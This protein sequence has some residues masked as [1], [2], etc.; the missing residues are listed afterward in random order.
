MS[1]GPITNSPPLTAPPTMTPN[2]IP[3]AFLSIAF[4]VLLQYPI[5]PPSI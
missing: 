2:I 4:N 5:G 1:I 3:R